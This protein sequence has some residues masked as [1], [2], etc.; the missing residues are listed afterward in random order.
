MSVQ[1]AVQRAPDSDPIVPSVPDLRLAV[2]LSRATQLKPVVLSKQLP[3]A[4]GANP[5]DACRT[6]KPIQDVTLDVELLLTRSPINDPNTPIAAFGP[7]VPL[8]NP[9]SQAATLVSL[10]IEGQVWKL[11]LAGRTTDLSRGVVHVTALSPEAD[12]DFARFTIDAAG[13]IAVGTL[14]LR[15]SVYRIVPDSTGYSVYKFGA[16]DLQQRPERY[17][18]V[19]QNCGRN[20]VSELERRHVQMEVLA[21]V[22]PGRVRILENAH[23]VLLQGGSL[24]SMPSTDEAVNVL[25]TLRALEPLIPTTKDTAV[26][27]THIFGKSTRNQA[28]AI[29]FEQVIGDVSIERRN[30]IRVD[31][32]GRINEIQSSIVDS[33]VFVLQQMI[34]E[35]HALVRAREALELQLNI[36]GRIKLTVPPELKYHFMQGTTLVPMYRFGFSIDSIDTGDSYWV[37]LDAT[38]GATE[39][40]P[41][42]IH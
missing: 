12:S 34:S 21:D 27:V 30:E 17:R 15:G 16:A 25:E 35:E 11:L 23:N 28:R 32:D 33:T 1:A 41:R 10:P 4:R 8:S 20:V 37:L 5:S 22:Q 29:R 18:R 3:V 31:P 39:I 6:D 38:S 9:Q 42:A 36:A 19:L 7:A 13:K 26:R 2:D 24:G 14:V 40:T